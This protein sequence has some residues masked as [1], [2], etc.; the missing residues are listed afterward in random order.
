VALS[1]PAAHRTI[2]GA[3]RSAE[4][5]SVVSIAPG[6][7]NESIVLD[8]NVSLVAEK[9]PGTVHVLAE[10]GP[11]LTVDAGSASAEIRGLT[12]EG[13]APRAAAVLLRGDA[14]VLRDCQVVGGRV[15]VC[16]S[17]A[18]TL[19]GCTVRG[20][21]LS[22]VRLSGTSRTTLE[23]CVVKRCEGDGVVADDDV[24]LELD[25][26]VIEDVEGRGVYLGGGA[27]ATLVR[28]E[29]RRSTGAGLL[30]EARAGAVLRECKLHELGGQG[31]R[32]TGSAGSSPGRGPGHGAGPRPGRHMGSS[33]EA[34][35]HAGQPRDRL[36]RA[37]AGASA[38][39]LP[40]G[41][42]YGAPGGTPYGVRLR[43]C[44]V[45]HTTGA[46]VFADG[47]TAAML[48]DCQVHHTGGAALIVTASGTMRLVRVR[49]VDSDDSALVVTGKADVTAEDSTFARTRANGVYAADDAQLAFARC[50]VEDTA[51]TA[52]HLGGSV[53]ARLTDCTVTGTPEYGLRS[54]DRAELLATNCE[55]RQAKLAGV[56]VDGGDAALR[57]CHIYGTRLG[58]RL[59]TTHRPLLADCEISEV[60][61]VGIEVGPGT[62][63][64]VE[65]VSV[66]GAGSSGVVFDIDSTVVMEACTV[67]E[68]G[69]SGIVVRAGARPRVRGTSVEKAGKN[70]LCIEKL[71]GGSYED[72]R[73]VGSRFPAVYAGAESRAQLRRCLVRDTE[74]DLLREEGAVVRAEECVADGVGESLLPVLGGGPVPGAARM[75]AV[76]PRMPAVA[77]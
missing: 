23:G 40:D 56:C 50:T 17:A 72:C 77:G 30:A 3:L 24:W 38:D 68:P 41:E 21:A 16:E 27:R 37:T 71:G 2:G 52:V 57:N 45:S 62:G 44:E 51:Y 46:G 8:K 13:P 33:G 43:A 39:A 15:E 20:A 6:T 10:T 28:C 70:A 73:L 31:V 47:G 22:A 65:N 67:V 11:A 12:F 53:R 19:A 66:L 58:V 4:P 14:P 9:G 60:S 1:S 55:L 42:S 36:P 32:L 64:L 35:A 29:I 49:G 54:T 26:T 7:Y 63:G 25:D 18:P 5:G 61:G 34:A 74:R 59:A 76:G 69:G 75:N 48:E